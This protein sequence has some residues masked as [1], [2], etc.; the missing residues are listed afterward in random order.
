MHVCPCLHKCRM[1]QRDETV[2]VAHLGIISES[3]VEILSGH[4]AYYI[5]YN[6]IFSDSQLYANIISSSYS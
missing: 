3:W 5:K 1:A 6:R 4:L 2:F